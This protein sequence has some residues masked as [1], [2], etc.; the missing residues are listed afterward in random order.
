MKTFDE[1]RREA[2]AETLASAERNRTPIPPLTDAHP[3]L[4]VE[5]AYAI[6]SLNIER[7]VAEGSPPPRCNDSSV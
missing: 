5:D 1:G 3:D 7:R 2:M 6:Q 4:T